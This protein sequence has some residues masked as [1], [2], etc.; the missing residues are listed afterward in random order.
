[1]GERKT[2]ELPLPTKVGLVE[3]YQPALP[4]RIVER[5][6]E[7]KEVVEEEEEEEEDEVLRGMGEASLSEDNFVGPLRVLIS[8]GF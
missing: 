6:E 3:E 1:V 8:C 7:Q 2:G 4:P 5:E